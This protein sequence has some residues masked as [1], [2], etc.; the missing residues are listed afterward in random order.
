MSNGENTLNNPKLG[1]GAIEVCLSFPGV[2]MLVSRARW[3]QDGA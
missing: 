3:E 2:G 1:S